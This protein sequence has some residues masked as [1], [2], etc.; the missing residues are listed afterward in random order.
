AVVAGE[1]RNLAQ[2][3][4]QAAK[5][6]KILIE[7]SVNRIDSGSQLV[8]NAGVT[9]GEIVNA[10]T[11]V[12]DIMGEIASASEEQSRGIDLVSTAVTEMDQ[13]T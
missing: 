2:R 13:V 10:V 3:S 1:V 7:D 12:T 9:M 11:R 8:E 4:A 5:E 6:I